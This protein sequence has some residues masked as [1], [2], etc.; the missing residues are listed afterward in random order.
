MMHQ[1]DDRINIEV[2]KVAFV[3]GIWNYVMKMNRA[4]RE[5]SYSR[6]IRSTSFATVHRLIKMVSLV[7]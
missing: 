3:N 5:Y 7:I 6:P 2:A 1:E 4:L